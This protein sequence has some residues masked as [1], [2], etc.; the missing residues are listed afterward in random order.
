MAYYTLLRPCNL[1]GEGDWSSGR[2]IHWTKKTTRPFELWPEAWNDNNKLEAKNIAIADWKKT[3]ARRDE[4]EKKARER[5]VE[6]DRTVDPNQEQRVPGSRHMPAHALAATPYDFAKWKPWLDII[7]KKLDLEIPDMPLLQRDLR[8]HL[9]PP[10]HREKNNEMP[11]IPW[12][13]CVARPVYKDEVRRSAGAQSIEERM[14]LPT[15]H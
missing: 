3:K 11:D 12:N 6:R 5:Q 1:E 10:K 15:A 8:E 4:C 9:L 14:G 7:N 2:Y 13:C